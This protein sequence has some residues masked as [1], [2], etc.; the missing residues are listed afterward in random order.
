MKINGKTKLFALLGCP[1]EHSYSPD[2]HNAQLELNEING[3]YMAF[4]VEEVDLETALKGLYVLGALGVNVT[5]PYKE[6]VIP[7]LYGISPEAKIIGAVNTLV[8]TNEGFYG[9][10]TD[11]K[12][13]LRSL[14]KEKNFFAENKK[15][16]IWGSGG[17]ARGVGVALAL[18]GA[19]EISFINRSIEKA[20]NLQNI[21]EA[22]SNTR[23]WAWDYTEEKIPEEKIKNADLL[24]NA[25]SIGMSP[26]VNLKPELNYNLIHSSQLVV[27]L[28]YNP[29]ETLFLKEACQRGAE[30]LNGSGMLYYQAELAFKLWTGKSFK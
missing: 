26:W 19:A 1:V 12:G 13:F 23:V 11:G 27:D 15:I 3:R 21:I 18:A 14:R 7:F 30:T 6:K 29:A 24:I 22:N 16:L 28:I 25:T 5:V 2:I 20:K 17:A 10:N 9:E 8:R 4:D